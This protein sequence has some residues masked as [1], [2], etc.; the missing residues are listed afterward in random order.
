M[1]TMR[2]LRAPILVLCVLILSLRSAAA[3]SLGVQPR[4]FVG[5]DTEMLQWAVTQGGLVLVVLVVVWSYRRDFTR[6]FAVER[7]RTSELLLA[8]QQ[9]TTALATH[10]EMMREASAAGRDQ[11]RAFTELSGSVKTCEMVR[12][13]MG[14]RGRDR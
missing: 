9:S 6:L 2:R 4:P 13:L 14:D 3:Q 8:L 7:E 10:A 1:A 5:S 11:A 12:E